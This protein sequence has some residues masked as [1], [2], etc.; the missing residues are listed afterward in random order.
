MTNFDRQ[1]IDLIATLTDEGQVVRL[2]DPVEDYGRQ[3]VAR[4]LRDGFAVVA[5][6]VEDH[7]FGLFLSTDDA[8]PLIEGT[9]IPLEFVLGQ[10]P[11]AVA[12]EDEPN[13]VFE[14]AADV[15]EAVDAVRLRNTKPS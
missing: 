2:S 10:A 13:L 11:W 12:L 8:L 7:Y 9:T 1:L 4:V 5:R 15:P 6:S 3:L 14:Y